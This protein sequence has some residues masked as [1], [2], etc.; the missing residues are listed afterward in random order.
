MLTFRLKRQMTPVRLID[1]DGTQI[2]CAL[3]GL[4]GTDF[5]QFLAEAAA[6]AESKDPNKEPAYHHTLAYCLYHATI[7]GEGEAAKVESLQQ[8]FT[9]D[10]VRRLPAAAKMP[11]FFEAQRMNNLDDEAIARA[12]N[13]LSASA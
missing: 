6:R 8:Q 9:I 13:G 5:D 1:D 2:D 12:K 3:V 11:L 10:E 4:E 7:S